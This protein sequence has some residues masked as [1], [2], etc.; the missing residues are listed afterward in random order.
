MRFYLVSVLNFS[1]IPASV[2]PS[3]FIVVASYAGCDKIAVVV[4]FTI[5]MAFMGCFYP[6]MKVN[7]LDLSP[8]YAGTI[9]AITN[10]IGA[11]TGIIAP[12]LVGVM[13]P[14]RLLIEWRTVFWIAF[15]VF[16]VT[17]LVY[18]LGASGEVQ[19]WNTPHLMNKEENGKRTEKDKDVELTNQ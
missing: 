7:P 11:I 8:N 18:I 15:G 16:N 9:M 19:P 13:T 17:N 6:G 4:H 5:A 10:G 3:I 1:S 12:S 2:F 14:N